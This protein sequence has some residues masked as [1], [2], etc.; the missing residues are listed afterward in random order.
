[1]YSRKYYL[2]RKL[3]AAGFE[4]EKKDNVRTILVPVHKI[5]KAQND[6]TIAELQRDHA[7]RVRVYSPHP[8]PTQLAIGFETEKPRR[9]L[10]IQNLKKYLKYAFTR[11][12][13]QNC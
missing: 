8:H 5:T 7:F 3:K 10:N 6:E 1:M 13:K 4:L 2:I 11:T 12:D 9:K